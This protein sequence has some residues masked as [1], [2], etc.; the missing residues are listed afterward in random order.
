MQLG[1]DFKS[2]DLTFIALT[3]QLFYRVTCKTLEAMPL[4]EAAFYPARKR[5]RAEKLLDA[6]YEQRPK[7]AHVI[8]GLTTVDISTTKGQHPDWGILGLATVSGGECVISKFRAQNS[9]RDERHIQQRLAKTVVHEVGHTL[10]LTHCPNLGCLMQDGKG[11]V[12]TTDHEYDLCPA[13]RT[14]L[15][16]WALDLPPEGPP[17]PKPTSP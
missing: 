11:T 13:C 10:G 1:S 8:I 7:D 17:W 9:A 15:G 6:L 3:V 2:D 12:L 5:Y 14:T 16:S 4:P